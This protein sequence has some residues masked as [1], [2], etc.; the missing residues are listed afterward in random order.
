MAVKGLGLSRNTVHELKGGFLLRPT[1]W[2]L[3]LGA[4][5]A[6]L[7]WLETLYPTLN[8]WLPVF[9]FPSRQDP[10]TAQLILSTIATSIMTVV[11]IV[12]AVML[13]TLTLA[14]MQFSPRII[15][16]FVR[17]KVTQTT[18]G[19]FL[20]TFTYCLTS[21]PAAH[22][23]PVDSAPMLT[24]FVGML[25]ALCSVGWLLYFIHHIS[26]AISVSHIVD[27]LA[28]DTCS[29]VRKTIP[30]REGESSTLQ[31]QGI[32][33]TRRLPFTFAVL[34]DR[35]GY[36]RSISFSKLLELTCRHKVQLRFTKRVGE[37]CTEDL[38]IA[39]L[40]LES[41]DEPNAAFLGALRACFE[42]GPTRT[43][44]QDVEFG[45]LQIV[46]IALK[47]I[48][49]AVND[50]STAVTC[51]D[52]LSR[53]LILAIQ[54]DSSP[55]VLRDPEG[56]IRLWLN[57][58]D[59]HRLM[60]AAFTQ[61]RLYARG[62]YAVSMRLIKVLGDLMGVAHRATHWTLIYQCGE[63]I[64]DGCRHHM[65]PREWH[66]L[67]ERWTQLGSLWPSIR[68]RKERMRAEERED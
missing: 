28:R 14:S 42:I 63:S 37:F 11:S 68:I 40:Y 7:S 66:L 17:D 51:V 41:D 35:T 21:L 31:A 50:P 48:S 52:Q 3:A 54:R 32:S 13:M 1:V 53:I 29:M 56:Q 34:A 8:S 9:L 36:L 10:Q 46:D 20:G 58:P 61:I 4:A 33:T 26:Q 12:F 15:V 5:G 44:Q 16:N 19:I 45:I 24:V 64:R 60:E 6:V 59:I 2:V 47:A 30:E 62:D 38:A 25:L 65:A 43:L 55:T 18:L 57:W 23:L 67:S 49:P 39:E 22:H 27:R